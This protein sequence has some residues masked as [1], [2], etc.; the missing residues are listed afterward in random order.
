MYLYLV[1]LMLAMII[2]V[3]NVILEQFITI[4]AGGEFVYNA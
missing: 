4:G 3:L 2:N 1:H